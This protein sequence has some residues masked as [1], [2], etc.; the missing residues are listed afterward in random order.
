M[1][2]FK[3]LEGVI[4]KIDYFEGITVEEMKM[5]IW[6][7]SGEIPDMQ[8]LIFA[9]KQLEDSRCASDYGIQGGA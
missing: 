1:L 6:S 5:A 9:G 8:R 2:Y 3:T 4:Y 7:V